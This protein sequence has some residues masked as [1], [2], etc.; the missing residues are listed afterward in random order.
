MCTG[1]TEQMIIEKPWFI[2]LSIFAGST[3]V[4]LR[5][6]QPQHVAPETKDISQTGKSSHF[7]TTPSEVKKCHFLTRSHPKC[8]QLEVPSLPVQ[9]RIWVLYKCPQSLF[10]CNRWAASKDDYN[11]PSTTDKDIMYQSCLA[12][13]CL[14]FFWQKFLACW[15]EERARNMEISEKVQILIIVQ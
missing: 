14:L 12:F 2:L 5:S 7:K 10:F 15:M 1:C 8:S 9:L 4:I 3:N 6:F 11:S 13:K